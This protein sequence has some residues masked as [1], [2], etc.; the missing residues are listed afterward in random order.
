MADDYQ[1][2]AVRMLADANVLKS[3]GRWFGTCY[4]SG[5]VVECYGKIV[6]EKFSPTAAA[7]LNHS[8]RSINRGMLG[9]SQSIGSIAAK[10]CLDLSVNCA[11]IYSH[12]HPSKRY[13]NDNAIWN[14]Q[15]IAEQYFNEAKKALNVITQMKLDGVI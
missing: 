1:N 15:A 11:T 14:T 12:W 13:A 6:I 3:G 7:S 9:I 5:Y 10:Y 2:T 4:L 8:V